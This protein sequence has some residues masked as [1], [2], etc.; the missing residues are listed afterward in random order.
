[1][2]LEDLVSRG[3]SALSAEIDGEVVALDIGKG[4]CY[5][6]DPVGSRVWA[7]IEQPVAVATVCQVLMREFDVDASTCEADVL[8]LFVQLRAE[9]LIAVRPEPNL[10]ST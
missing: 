8:D 5:G 4:V 10:P 7:L 6:L 9:G 2:T 1:M 3:P